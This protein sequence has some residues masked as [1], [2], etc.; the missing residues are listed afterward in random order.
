MLVRQH[1]DMS[2]PHAD[3]LAQAARGGVPH[4]KCAMVWNVYNMALNHFRGQPVEPY[5][6]YS[7]FAR[8]YLNVL[9]DVSDGGQLIGHARAVRRYESAF[10]HLYVG[11][12]EWARA[13]GSMPTRQYESYEALSIGAVLQEAWTVYSTLGN[14]AGFTVPSCA[15]ITSEL[16]EMGMAPCFAFH[17]EYTG[18][19][20]AL[21]E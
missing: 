5:H 19:W 20:G 8:V 2:A 7:Q 13:A 1:V 10:L 4:I 9:E 21:P 3:I 14:R 16:S 11:C 18:V 6:M 12:G 17:D 15:T